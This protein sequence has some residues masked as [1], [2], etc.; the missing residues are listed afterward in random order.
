MGNAKAVAIRIARKEG[1]VC[2]KT[3]VISL[4]LLPQS[5]E[6]ITPKKTLDVNLIWVFGWTLALRV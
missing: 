1:F 3:L 2:I 6:A 4:L 5:D